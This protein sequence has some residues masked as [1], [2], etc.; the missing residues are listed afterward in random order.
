MIAKKLFSPGFTLV[1]LLVTIGIIVILAAGGM[2]AYS[3]SQKRGRD[4][5][6]IDD[7]KAMQNSFEQYYVANNAYA[8]SC[9][10]MASEI[11][12]GLPV[13]PNGGTYYQS[14]SSTLAY[15]V[16]ATLEIP[17]KGNSSSGS[18]CTSFTTGG[19][20]FCVKSLQ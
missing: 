5:R 2:S 1:E 8:T 6:R 14:C 19:D 15:C 7:L 13:D 10:T 18:N 4:I 11:Q 17:G 3:T 16:C 20:Y 12:G 9:S